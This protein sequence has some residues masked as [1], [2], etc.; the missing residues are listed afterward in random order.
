MGPP[1]VLIWQPHRGVLI[2]LPCNERC[3]VPHPQAEQPPKTVIPAAAVPGH[4][5]VWW[6]RK[7]SQAGARATPSRDASP[8]ALQRTTSGSGSGDY[9][10]AVSLA[11][12]A[13]MKVGWVRQQL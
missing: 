4:R 11:T 5:R 9:Y 1:R 7:A 13:P 2:P 8:Q 12:L 10:D 3:A 6:G